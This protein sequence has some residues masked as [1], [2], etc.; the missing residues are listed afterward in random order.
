MSLFLYK[1]KETGDGFLLQ[2]MEEEMGDGE[3]MEY[4]SGLHDHLP[5]CKSG[6]A[7]NDWLP[8]NTEL[9]FILTAS[10]Y[11]SDGPLVLI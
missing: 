8:Y 6:M 2:K 4:W 11:Q 10:Q 7:G 3:S 5:V 1:E 9:I